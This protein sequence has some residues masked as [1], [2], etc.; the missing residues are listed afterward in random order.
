[1]GE[2]FTFERPQVALPFSGERM[3]SAMT[4]QIEYEHLHRY[5]LA[6]VLVRGLDVVDIASGEGYGTALLSQTARSVVGVEI[7]AGS[8]SHA[9]RAYARPG[10]SFVEGDARRIPLAD[11][12]ADVVVSFETIEHFFEHDA[13]LAETRRILRPGGRLIISSPDRDVYSPLD[14]RVNPFHVHELS[15]AEFTVLLQ[16]HF[17]HVAMYAQRPLVGSALLADGGP[18]PHDIM[19][20]EKRGEHLESSSGLPRAFYALAIASDAPVNEDISSIYIDTSNVDLP[21]TLSQQLDQA[22]GETGAARAHAEAVARELEQ[23][24]QQLGQA[25]EALSAAKQQHDTARDVTRVEANATATVLDTLRTEV[26]AA[27]ARSL[28]DG[29]RIGT[30]EHD[31]DAAR[32]ETALRAMQDKEDDVHALY[33]AARARMVKLEHAL[34]D[35]EAAATVT[36]VIVQQ[37]EAAHTATNSQLHEQRDA[38]VRLV[39]VI[40]AMEQR[41]SWRITAPLRR[42][43]WA[44]QSRSLLG[45]T[46][47]LALWTV[48]LQLPRRARQYL[49]LRRDMAAIAVSGLFDSEWTIGQAAA[50]DIARADP[51]GYYMRQGCFACVSPHPLFDPTHYRVQLQTRNLPPL[52]SG[53]EPLTHFLRVGADLGCDPHPWFSVS[54]YKAQYP[55]LAV[56]ALTHYLSTGSKEGA[57][58]HPDFFGSWYKQHYRD[59]GNLDPLLHFV[60]VGERWAKY[61]PNSFAID[62]LSRLRRDTLGLDLP[63]PKLRI[64]VGIVTYNSD[65]AQLA[66]CLVSAEVAMGRAGPVEGS[67]VWLIDNGAST[68]A[69]LLAR[70]EMETLPTQGNLGFGAAHNVLMAAAFAGGADLYVATNPDGFFHP[71]CLNYL[72]RMAIA[73]QGRA[74]IEAL[75]FPDEHPKGY[76]MVDFETPWASGACLAI[77]RQLYATVGGFD[78]AFFMYC[79]DVD[80]SWRTRAAGY[81]VKTNPMALFYHSVADR[82]PSAIDPHLLKSGLILARKWQGPAAFTGGIHA[83]LEELGL[84]EPDLPTITPM[85][86][87]LHVPDFSRMFH[88]GPVRW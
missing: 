81:E 3:T 63:A 55:D 75:Q 40:R 43:V 13:F 77:P 49:R 30:L 5:L 70:F 27:S 37:Q 35:A 41:R 34:N 78:E 16:R 31:L 51:L 76:D 48:T 68:E 2:I 33:K 66:R 74:M 39:A 44:V 11:A 88:F 42:M 71:D 57:S 86:I 23:F 19:T 4:G 73:A 53:E 6:R 65:P 20:F 28:Q 61:Q 50:P 24:R 69:S 83:R 60:T 47:R 46:A 9:T 72:A 10:L 64:A 52:A 56:N 26:E 85:T 79:E 54:H 59:I 14:G 1:M 80:L 87:G 17:C 22:R 12:S 82:D 84:P 67:G 25:N 36:R 7:D 38:Y 15:R 21:H 18:R 32:R 29:R 62:R 45:K 8:V 58:S